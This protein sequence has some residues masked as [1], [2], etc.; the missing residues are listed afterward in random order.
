MLYGTVR[1]NSMPE[2]ALHAFCIIC[3][4]CHIIL[5]CDMESKCVKSKICKR[6]LISS[7]WFPDPEPSQITATTTPTVI[8]SPLPLCLAPDYGWL[9][10]QRRVAVA[11]WDD[12][13]KNTS[14]SLQLILPNRPYQWN[15][16]GFLWID[17]ILFSFQATHYCEM[18]LKSKKE[19]RAIVLFLKPPF[20]FCS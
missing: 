10:S 9:L 8:M 17:L 7:L 11:L 3:F 1:W 12:R 16:I 13:S 18:I 15:E 14:E 20:V 6:M 4:I 5:R 19:T 2:C